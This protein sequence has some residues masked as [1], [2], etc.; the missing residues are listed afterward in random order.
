MADDLRHAAGQPT[1]EVREVLDEDHAVDLG[2][3]F[4]CNDYAHAVEFAFDLLERRDPRREGVIGGLAVVK[5]D[6][7]KRETVW[8][9]SHSAHVNRPDPIRRWGWDVTRN[10][11]GP[12]T[13]VRPLTL[14]QRIRRA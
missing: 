1:Y 7:G 4:R 5:T 13:H 2:L 14:G 8:T 11:Q 9:Y 6:Q 3:L 12:A 10:W